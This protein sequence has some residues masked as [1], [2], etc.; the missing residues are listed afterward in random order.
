MENREKQDGIRSWCQLV[1]QHE[2]DGNENVRIKRLENFINKVFHLNY[3]GVLVKF[4]QGYENAFIEL[5]LIGQKTWDDDEIKKRRFVQDARN[6]GL[7]HTFLK[8]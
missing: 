6:I 5:V 8:K 3:R 1:Q 2:T 7:V 4:I